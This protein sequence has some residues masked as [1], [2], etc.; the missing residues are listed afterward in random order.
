MALHLAQRGVAVLVTYGMAKTALEA[1]TCLLALE[2]GPRR[3]GVNSLVPGAIATDIG[4]GIVKNDPAV[5]DYLATTIAL[6]RVGQPDDIGRALASLLS[7]DLA[8]ANGARLE[9]TGG[10]FL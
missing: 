5:G 9:L 4:G 2:L 3:S 1:M 10:Q 8:W 6:G 7:D